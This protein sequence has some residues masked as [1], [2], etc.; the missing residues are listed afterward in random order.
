MIRSIVRLSS[1]EVL[2]RGGFFISGI[3]IYYSSSSVF[4]QFIFLNSIFTLAYNTVALGTPFL[5]AKILHREHVGSLWKLRDLWILGFILCCAGLFIFPLY[6]LYLLAGFAMMMSEVAYSAF[7]MAGS[8][9][10]FLALLISGSL[11]FALNIASGIFLFVDLRYF[12]ILLSVLVLALYLHRDVAKLVNAVFIDRRLAKDFFLDGLSF[13]FT[14]VLF[15]TRNGLDKVILFPILA[16]EEYA[17]YGMYFF[18]VAAV[19][20][21]W[22]SFLRVLQKYIFGFIEGRFCFFLKVQTLTVLFLAISVGLC[23][24]FEMSYGIIILVGAMIHFSN[25]LLVVLLNYLFPVAL[26]AAA[27]LFVAAGYLLV[28]WVLPI[29]VRLLALLF[30]GSNISLSLLYLSIVWA[31]M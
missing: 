27:N 11:L 7:R 18:V 10:I 16:S 3:I 24:V 15:W 9:R 12:G 21:I 6:S 26:Y 17:I 29:D 13:G 28:I 31:R 25:Q 4:S 23:E 1:L 20:A 19:Q 8:K 2:L 5:I 14:H 22:T 30:A